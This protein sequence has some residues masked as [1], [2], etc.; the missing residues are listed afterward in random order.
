MPKRKRQASPERPALQSEEL[1]QQAATELPDR[2]AMSVV[3]LG[4]GGTGAA[5]FAVPINTAEAVNV[6]SNY[7]Y[8]I[9]DAD[10]VVDI[11][12]VAEAPATTEEQ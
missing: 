12:Q 8:A 4:F 9:A 2:E 6:Y 10:Q 3:K 1:D 7:S 5:N 11:D